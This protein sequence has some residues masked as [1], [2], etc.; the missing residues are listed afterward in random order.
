MTETVRLS[1]VIAPA[2]AS[3]HRQL[4]TS[5]SIELWL[6]G[7]RG[8]T[9]SSFAALEII[10]DIM[11]DPTANA[12]VLRKVG[13]TIRSSV[14]ETIEWAI[15]T[16]KV[17]HLFKTTVSPPSI[18]YIPTGQKILF[19]GL[20]KAFKL[21]SIKVKK[22]YFK[23]IWFEEAAEFDGMHEIRNV[24]QSAKRGGNIFKTIL[25]YNPPNDPQSWVNKESK[26]EKPGR[27]VHHSTYLDV[28]EDWL[29][30]EFITDAE[31]L[32]E[33]NP[34]AYDHEYGGIAVGLHES[35]IFGSKCVVKTFTPEPD[36]D[37]PYLGADWGF[38]NDPST[39]VKCWIKSLEPDKPIEKARKELYIE[40][41]EFGHKVELDDYPAFYSGGTDSEK[42]E[43]DGVPDSKKYKIWADSS[44][45]ET[46][47]HVKNKGY[48]IVG[49]EKWPGSVE[50]GITV[51][52]SFYKIYIHT[53]CE[54]M[55]EEARLYAYKIDKVTKEVTPDIVDKFNHGWDAV[56]YALSKYIKRRSKGFFG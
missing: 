24:L 4:M 38:A 13:E 20:D 25:S 46:I 44:R 39:L 31:W 35:I 32:R 5:T 17:E 34:L 52:V 49:A 36:W 54:E 12:L 11:R 33:N 45:P 9:K 37:G 1:D 40:Y 48:N 42:R 27:V 16:L 3:V 26:V 10:L 30:E 43:W 2:F 19:K 41:A 14:L 47:S 51:L 7:G 23:W 29:G 53:R 18:T 50:D 6:K 15:Q 8:S 22:G 56:R 28:P 21:K 55:Q